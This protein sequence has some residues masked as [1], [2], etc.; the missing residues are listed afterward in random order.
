[1]S[2]QKLS[3]AFDDRCVLGAHLE[4]ETETEMRVNYL[5]EKLSEIESST[6]IASTKS[7]VPLSD[8]FNTSYAEFLGE[9]SA[10]Y[11]VD[12]VKY[13]FESKSTFSSFQP[14]S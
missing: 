8:V 10:E 3:A 1:M 2:L 13:L 9:D 7:H 6:F 11:P 4:F 5:K 14:L 12:Q